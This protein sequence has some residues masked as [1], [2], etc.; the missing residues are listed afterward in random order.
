[1]NRLLLLLETSTPATSVALATVGPS[2]ERVL[3]EAH[4]TEPMRHTALLVPLIRE[5]FA[6]LS[7][8]EAEGGSRGGA[9][10][11]GLADLAAVAVSAGPGSYTALRAGLS[12]AKGLCLARGL[13]LIQVSTLAAIASAAGR[14]R[15]TAPDFLPVI[16]AR[17]RE[18]YCA[19]Y[20]G[21]GTEV[22]APASAVV[23]EAWGRRQ[24]DLG[25]YELCGPAA[26]LAERLLA[27]GEAAPTSPGRRVG[28][29]IPAADLLS[30]AAGDWR[31]GRFADLAGAVPHYL[32]PPHVTVPKPRL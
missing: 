16:H 15:A 3:A 9:A 23:D 7:L 18:V 24:A 5:A 25:P 13:P 10:P 2:G 28:L 22:L 27:G 30:L 20:R 19:R 8:G 32:K 11:P 6:K 17:R 12:A 31:A 4:S 29:S 21:D 14:S 1:M 26:S